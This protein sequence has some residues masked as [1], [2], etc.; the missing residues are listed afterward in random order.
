MM[1]SRGLALLLVTIGCAN[2][3]EPARPATPALIDV[4]WGQTIHRGDL[5]VAVPGTGA[6]SG[7]GKWI[8]A[9]VDP[10]DP[11]TPP[12]IDA[13]ANPQLNPIVLEQAIAAAR[14]A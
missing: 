14:R 8:D 4:V 11:N 13:V 12:V 7:T 3:D 10:A 1:L 5:I 9:A 2:L 6:Y